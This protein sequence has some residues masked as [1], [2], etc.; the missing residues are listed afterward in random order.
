[1]NT[2]PYCKTSDQQVKSGKTGAGS[3]R[4]KCKAC[5]RKYTPE[6]K[7]HGYPDSVRELAVRMMHEG[8]NYRR[9]ARLIGVDHKTVIHW[10]KAYSDQLPPAPVPHDVNNAELDELYT[11]IGKK[12]TRSTSLPK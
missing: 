9:T 10:F 2:C 12:K 3:Q 7:E 5:G 4:W 1:M 11:F 8:N 6:P